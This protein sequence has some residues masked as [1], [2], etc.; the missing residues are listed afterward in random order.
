MTVSQFGW[1]GYYMAREFLYEEDEFRVYQG[2]DWYCNPPRLAQ[3]WQVVYPDGDVTELSWVE[4]PTPRD[5][6]AIVRA[7]CIF[8][9]LLEQ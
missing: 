3:R 1:D 2:L 5:A 8:N 9:D 4:A 7:H 6:V